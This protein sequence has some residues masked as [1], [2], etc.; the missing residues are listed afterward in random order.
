MVAPL[1]WWVIHVS[2]SYSEQITYWTMCIYI[3]VNCQHGWD[4]EGILSGSLQLN[5]KIL[6]FGLL[7]CRPKLL[8]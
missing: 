5:N 8:R 3:S 2:Q 1:G 7:S 4:L 6:G